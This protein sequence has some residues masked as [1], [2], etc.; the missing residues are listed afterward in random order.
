[1]STVTE[2]WDIVCPSC[3]KDD[4]IGIACT[5]WMRLTPDGTT[6]EDTNGDHE[7]T[8]ESAAVCHHC[9]WAGDVGAATLKY[10][11]LDDGKEL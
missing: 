6:D 1:M 9:H 11:D 10:E 7:W 8:P 2:E 5:V 3:G 4:K